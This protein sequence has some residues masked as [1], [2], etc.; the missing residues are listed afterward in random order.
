MSFV[1]LWFLLFLALVVA[2]NFILP[3]RFRYIWLLAA[4]YFFYGFGSYWLLSL[5]IGVTVACYL[6]ALAIDKYRKRGKWFLALAIAVSLGLLFVFKYLDFAIGTVVSFA[7]LFGAGWKFDG[8]SIILPVGISFYTFQ[9]LSYVIDVYRGRTEA[10]RHIGYFALFVSFFPQ[11]VAGPI[12]RFDRLMPQL[13]SERAFSME[14]LFAGG[15]Y[16]VSGFLKKVVIADFLATIINPIYGDIAGQDGSAIL[17]ATILFAFQIYGDFSGYSDIA[18]GS[19]KILG[20]DLMENF[21]SPYASTSPRDFWRRWHI[22]LSK[23]FSDY[24]YIPLGG[25]RKGKARQCLNLFIVFLIS[26][27]WHGADLKFIAWGALHGLYLV[28]ETLLR[29]PQRESG[30]ALTALKVV[31]TFILVDFAWIFFRADSLGDAGLAIAK[32]FT[33]WGDFSW[34]KASFTALTAIRLA[35]SL[36]AMALVKRLPAISLAE[37]AGNKSAI[38]ITSFA[39]IAIIAGW[40]LLYQSGGGSQ[41]IY[42]QF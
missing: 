38:F 1:S 15:R 4:S 5:I 7:N 40:A 17:V 19:A 3:H 20:I 22:S 31:G 13:K 42:F 35:L 28:C 36:M 18:K 21:D 2:V 37:G 25:N 23:W 34:I 30:L 26:G 39:L 14:N 29:R 32:I 8:L 11:L 27:L 41:F 12:E 16:M 24:C 33:S 9:S 6:C 10:E